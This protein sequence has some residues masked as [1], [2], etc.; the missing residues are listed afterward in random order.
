MTKLKKCI[1]CNIEK[2]LTAFPPKGSK[3]NKELRSTKCSSCKSKVKRSNDPNHERSK[4]L[5]RYYN[6][7]LL[8]YEEM[9]NS[10]K[11]LCKICCK[12]AS[13]LNK[14][15]KI[16][17]LFVDHCHDT[18]VVRGLLCSNCNTILGMSKDKIEI[19]GRAIL[20][21]KET[22]TDKS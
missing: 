18:Q 6:L 1:S 17:P 13:R 12:P 9:Y 5:K 21:L 16:I 20:Y 8:Q 2:Q 15:G 11:G 22:N 14:N 19:L 4:N 3:Y 10:Q 7:T